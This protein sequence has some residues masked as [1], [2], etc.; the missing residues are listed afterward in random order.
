MPSCSDCRHHRDPYQGFMVLLPAR[1]L[2]NPP[3]DRLSGLRLPLS[4][5]AKNPDG[6]CAEHEARAQEPLEGTA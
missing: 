2:S 1:C 5:S 3:V 4:C 6:D